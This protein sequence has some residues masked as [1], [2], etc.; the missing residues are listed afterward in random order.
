[1]YYIRFWYQRYVGLIK[2]FSIL[3]KSFARLVLFFF[4]KYLEAFTGKTIWPWSFPCLK[5]M[6][7][8][9]FNFFARYGTIQIFYFFFWPFVVCFKKF[10]YYI[11]ILL[12]LLKN[13]FTGYRYVGIFFLHFKDTIPSSS[14]FDQLHLKSYLSVQLLLLWR[15]LIFLSDASK[16]FLFGFRKFYYN[17]PIYD[18]YYIYDFVLILFGLSWASQICGLTSFISFGKILAIIP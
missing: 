4:L 17:V 12:S 13:T 1:M 2:H 18:L 14:G 15:Y 9:R 7:N 8:L 5:K 3:Q 6:L 16:I 11:H 10:I